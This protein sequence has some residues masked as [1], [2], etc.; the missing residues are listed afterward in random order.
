MDTYVSNYEYEHKMAFL[1][2]FASYLV[3]KEFCNYPLN[4]FVVCPLI[5]FLPA[6]LLRTNCIAFRF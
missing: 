3:Q 2:F 6:D 1:N 4:Y 5:S